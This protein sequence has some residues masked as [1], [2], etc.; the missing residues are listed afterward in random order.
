[1]VFTSEFLLRTTHFLVIWVLRVEN[2]AHIVRL[3]SIKTDSFGI[4]IL[5]S[6]LD[7]FLL[8][9]Q[10]LVIS[11]KRRRLLSWFRLFN[12][13]LFDNGL[14]VRSVLIWRGGIGPLSLLNLPSIL[15]LHQLL[16]I[17]YWNGLFVRF[18]SQI[19]PISQN[20]CLNLLL[21]QRF[22]KLRSWAILWLVFSRS[23]RLDIDK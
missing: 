20:F 6:F 5:S 13:Y 10:L 4:Y 12:N 15:L 11:W 23:I 18:C 16:H 1:M 21:S 17:T 22:M 8:F 14:C 7:K 3:I 19:L 9:N 2:G